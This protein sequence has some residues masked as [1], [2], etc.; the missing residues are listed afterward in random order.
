MDMGDGT[1]AQMVVSTDRM[2]VAGGASTYRVI[3]AATANAAVIKPT[4]AI[5]YGIQISNLAPLSA[6][7]AVKLYNQSTVPLATDVPAMVFALPPNA[8]ID[9]S[10][11]RGV[12]FPA[13]LAIAIVT[14]PLDAVFAAVGAGDVT[15]NLNFT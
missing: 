3:S 12:A 6:T 5:L 15:A 2:I 1:K 7:R 8:C 13:G 10:R 14:G 9:I 11:S 4:A